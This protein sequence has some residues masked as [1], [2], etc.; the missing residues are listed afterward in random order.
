MLRCTRFISRLP[1]A[2]SSVFHVGFR[3]CNSRVIA[4]AH[5]DQPR[6][7]FEVYEEM[8]LHGKQLNEAAYSALISSL[9]KCDRMCEVNALVDEMH[10]RSLE[11]DAE[12][13]KDLI[14]A[15]CSGV[16]VEKAFIIVRYL[17]NRN[18]PFD[19]SFM[20][21]LRTYPSLYTK[22]ISHGILYKE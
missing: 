22:L 5:T 19:A 11:A 7:A 3:Q 2:S 18:Y 10:Q 15:Y 9:I 8:K 1:L 17:N 12:T 16:F 4:Y 14:N 21:T 13:Y 20:Q 6:T